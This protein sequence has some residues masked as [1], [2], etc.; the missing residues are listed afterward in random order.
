MD[1]I[2]AVQEEDG[3]LN[4]YFTIEA[5]ERK[6]KRL[7]QS[8]E[9]YCAGHFIEAAVTYH[10][11][12]G[13][14][15]V[16]SGMALDGK[17]FFYVNP[18]EVV[19]ELSAKNPCKSHIKT[20]RP[21]WFSCACCPPNLAR[22]LSSLD[23]YVYTVK[24]D[25]VY[26]NL[27]LN[28]AADLFLGGQSVKLRQET[29]YPWNGDVKLTVD[30]EG[31]FALGVRVPSW[32][33]DFSL[34]VNGEPMSAPLEKG[35]LMVKRSWKAGDVVELALPM[36]ASFYEAAPGV[37]CDTNRVAVMRGPLVY[38]AESVDN[39][40]ELQPLCVNPETSISYRFAEDTLG[41]IG[42]LETAGERVMDR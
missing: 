40:V 41:G 37:R 3:Y 7:F 14:E 26:A 38:C 28:C 22:L 23:Q 29:Q 36:E 1:L 35:Y 34:K 11:A 33:S 20:T 32:A 42:V 13:N 30:S 8:H 39:G 17:H 6:F 4:T 24:D 31:T 21:A 18:L 9:L 12:T 15:K 25:V 10:A 16:L 27:Y 5:H 2:A 19:P